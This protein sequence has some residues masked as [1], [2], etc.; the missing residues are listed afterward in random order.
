MAVNLSSSMVP[1]GG[2]VDVEIKIHTRLNISS[3][4]AKQRTHVCLALRC[5]QSFA[6]DEPI[7][8]VEDRVTW[9]VPVWLSTPQEGRK[10]KIGDLLVDAQTG[11]V[12]DEGERC[13]ELKRIANALLHTSSPA[14]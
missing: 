10:T 11:E 4:V 14:E 12:L 1:A 13:R 6:V 9:L 3:Y 7:L 8:Q 2:D 5:G